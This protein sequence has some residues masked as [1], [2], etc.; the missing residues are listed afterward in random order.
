MLNTLNTLISKVTVHVKT[1]ATWILEKLED[2]WD[3]HT[4][5]LR[6][7]ESY[8]RQILILSGAVLTTLAVSGPADAILAAAAAA[9]VTAHTADDLDRSQW[10]A[11]P[12][13]ISRG[14]FEDERGW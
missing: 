4:N 10:T 12:A 6:T 11:R 3:A 14:Y 9:Y 1:A 8:R 5:A 2:L 13:T 7:S